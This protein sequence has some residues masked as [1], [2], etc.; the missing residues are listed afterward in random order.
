[1]AYDSESPEVDVSPQEGSA[2]SSDVGSGSAYSGEPAGGGE[3]GGF[4]SPYEA[5]KSLPDFEGKSDLDIARQLYHAHNTVG[6][7]QR[8]LAQYQ[9]VMGPATQNYLRN[10]NAFEAWQRSQAEAAKP[11]PAEVA[12]WWN[13]PQVKDTWRNFVV[14]DPQT[15]K[16]VISADAPYEAKQALQEYQSYTTDF[17]RR[18]VTDP[19]NT[20]KPF[21]EQIAQQ[22]AQ[23][24]VQGQFGQYAATNYVSDL[25]K[26]NA[27]WLYDSRGQVTQE[28]AAIQQ[29]IADA[30]QLGISSPEGRWKYAAS[31]LRSDLMNARHA[32]MQQGYATQQ[33]PQAAPQQGRA[34]PDAVA[35]GNMKFLRD[36]ATRTPNRSAGTTEPQAPRGRQ[37]FNDRLVGQLKQDGVI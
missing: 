9:E 32:Q 11:K 22:K 5:F 4:S 19:E 13:P 2:G 16:E 31:M 6:E 29:Y 1:M 23:E 21:I 7:S 37:T 24:L 17:A 35:T 25:E 30:T 8:Q 33:S 20:L 15:G 14:R 10:Q 36:R 34:A 18:L 27:D 28:G 12:P 26:Q 3:D